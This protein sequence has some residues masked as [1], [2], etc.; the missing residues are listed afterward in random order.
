MRAPKIEH[1]AIDFLLEKI[2]LISD[3]YAGIG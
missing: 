3:D 1:C 2:E